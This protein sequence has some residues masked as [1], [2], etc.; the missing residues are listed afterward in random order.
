MI[1]M[2]NIIIVKSIRINFVIKLKMLLF[3]TYVK[4]FFTNKF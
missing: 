3:I 1:Y 4:L 2:I